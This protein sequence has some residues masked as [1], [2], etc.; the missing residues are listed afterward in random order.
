MEQLIVELNEIFA[1]KQTTEPGDI[2]L[3]ASIDPQLL[4]Y[5]YVGPII[6]DDS[7]KDEWWHVTFHLLTIPLQTVV[8]TLRTPQFTGQ[9]SFTMG[10]EG[11]FIKAIRF[12]EKPP[13]LP[14]ETNSS[15]SPKNVQHRKGL[16]IIK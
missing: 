9:E 1:F 8:W 15:L 10:G 12:V 14:E 13:I 5:A 2:V 7:R 16:R 3:I 4:L 6:R 11:R